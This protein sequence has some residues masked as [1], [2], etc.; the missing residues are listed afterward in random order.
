MIFIDA[1]T[2][3]GGWGARGRAGEILLLENLNFLPIWC[4]LCIGIYTV[5][6]I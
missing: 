3:Q 2:P 1:A 6:C 4:I 5:L